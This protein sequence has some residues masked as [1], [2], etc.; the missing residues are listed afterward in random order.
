VPANDSGK[1]R[2]EQKRENAFFVQLIVDAM[3]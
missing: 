3:N 1:A 2:N